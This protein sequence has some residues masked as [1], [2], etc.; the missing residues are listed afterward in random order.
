MLDRDITMDML[1]IM[2]LVWLFNDQSILL[3]HY[4]QN[5]VSRAESVCK[6]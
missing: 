4:P 3:D 5:I 2:S 1:N 6:P